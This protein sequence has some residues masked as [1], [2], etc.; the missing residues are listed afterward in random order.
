M[1]NNIWYYVIDGVRVGP[2]DAGEIARLIDTGTVSAQTLVW[3]DGLDGWVAA[4][5]HFDISKGVAPVSMPPVPPQPRVQNTRP[6][7]D[8][9][10]AGAAPARGFRDSINT[11]LNKYVTFSGRAS[12]SE[13]WY[14]VL[15]TV[16]IG[17]VSGLVDGIIFPGNDVSPINSIVSL[18]V[19]LPGLSVAVRRLHD[20]GRSGWWIGSYY[21]GLVAYIVVASVS[22]GGATA[23]DPSA[24]ALSLIGLGGIAFLVM[25][26]VLL[27]FFCTR[28]EA[29]RNRFG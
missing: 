1:S 23:G 25:T 17:F 4:S 14:F 26:V 11:C 16:L 7:G 5:E 12:R 10:N 20:I 9:P 6:S 18:A 27:V 8:Q 24:L 3:R 19:L 22:V 13:Y 15:F 28:G 21:L 29:G 2:V